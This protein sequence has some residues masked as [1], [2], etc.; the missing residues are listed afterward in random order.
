MKEAL[1]DFDA[2]LGEVLLPVISPNT[3]SFLPQAL[4][5]S[6]KLE[7]WIKSL[8]EAAFNAL[9]RGEHV[10]GWK[11]VDKRGTRKWVHPE[12]MEKTGLKL[13]GENIYEVKLKT[14]AQFEKISGIP[15][16]DLKAFTK[17]HSSDISSGVTLVPDSDPREPSK[18]L[19]ELDFAEDFVPKLIAPV[20]KQKAPKNYYKPWVRAALSASK[21]LKNRKKEIKNGKSKKRK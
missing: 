12:T 11:L 7:V 20:K 2:E 13:F 14:P 18:T 3:V 16:K 4:K 17:E 5:A 15:K 21:K 19:A 8:R 1:I 10:A 9:S 6:E